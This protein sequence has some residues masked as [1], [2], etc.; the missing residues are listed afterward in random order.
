MKSHAVE[1]GVFIFLGVFLFCA[2]LF[3]IGSTSNLF[4]AHFVIYA[5]FN[6]ISSIA[7]G[8]TVR[9]R[10]M[11]AG[12]VTGIAVPKT[13]A[14]QFRLKLSVD[15]KF[16]PVVREDSVASIETAGFVGNKFVN[17]ARGT[18]NSPECPAG[19]TLK[20]QESVSM[21]ELM[22][23]G[24]ALVGQIQGTVKRADVAVQN[25]AA[26]GKNANRIILA[27]KPKI[28][29]MTANANAIVAGIRNGQGAAGKLLTDK[30]VASNVA[31]TIANARQA[32]ANFA[33]T[34][35]KVS[36]IVSGVQQND[37][38]NVHKTVQ[39]AQQLTGL[40]KP[41][42]ALS[43]PRKPKARPTRSVRRSIRRSRPWTIWRGIRKP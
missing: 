39:N 43:V 22:R 29:Q 15:N 37:M 17:I 6:D 2:G 13:P 12:Q 34:S 35:Q 10:G 36:G 38:P 33:Q 20:S 26:V 42:E 14:G 32:S 7:K 23:K 18:A 8:A 31:A 4:G 21:G 27:M 41:W 11:D 30:A 1:V 19:C 40:T 3:L 5:K 28:D 16:H 25:F 24:G 9:V